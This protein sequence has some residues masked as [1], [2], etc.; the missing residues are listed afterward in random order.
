MITT[1]DHGW[2][3][4]ETSKGYLPES[5]EAFDKKFEEW[6]ARDWSSWLS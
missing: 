1:D 3:L 4:R 2:D 5:D 6:V